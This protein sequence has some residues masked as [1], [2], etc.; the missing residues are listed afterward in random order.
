MLAL[1][2][3]PNIF[4]EMKVLHYPSPLTKFTQEIVPR[5]HLTTISNM[6]K[7]RN[8]TSATRQIPYTQTLP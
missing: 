7:I 6:D 5:I 4:K 8:H 1:D 3:L 2:V